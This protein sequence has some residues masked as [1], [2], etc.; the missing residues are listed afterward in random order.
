MA[1]PAPPSETENAFALARELRQP[2][3]SRPLQGANNNN[4]APTLQILVPLD[5]QGKFG[6]VVMGEYSIDGLLRFGV[7][8]EITA[9]YAV[10]LVDD[11]SRVLAGNMPPPR[12]PVVRLLPWPDGGGEYEIPV[13]PVGN[14]LLIKAQ[15]YRTSLGVVGSGFFWLVSA[16]SALT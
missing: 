16:L 8:T 12:N 13:S 2:V 15:A 4:T 9:K 7:P 11:K 1:N 14:G 10:T 5:E 3:Y 6:G